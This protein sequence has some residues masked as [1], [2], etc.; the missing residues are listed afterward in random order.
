MAQGDPITP[1]PDAG[2]TD[3]ASPLAVRAFRELWSANALS[4][5]GS[6][7]QVVAAAWLMA[8]LTSSAQMI[9][10][11]QTATSLPTVCFILL[12]GALADN[13][14]RRRIMIV[15]QSAMLAVAIALAAFS[16]TGAIT[17]WMLLLL[18]FV[19]QSFNALNN[20]NWQGSVRDLLPRSLISRAVALNSTSMNLARTA[21][22]ALGGAI[23]AVAGISAA[24][25]VNACSFVAFLV[26]LR[27]WKPFARERTS[28]REPVG[29]AIL[30]G[31]RY[32]AYHPDVRNAVV[33][34]GL[35]GLSASAVFALLPVL[36]RH[37]LQTDAFTFGVLLGCFGG[38]AVI[39]A[40]CSGIVRSRF[41]PDTITRSA[42]AALTLGLL[43]LGFAHNVPVAAV[44]AAFGGAGWTMAH[45]T[46]NTTVQLA[47]APWVTARSL[48]FYQTA[49][50]A[51][52]ASGSW[53]LGGIAE[54]E[55]LSVAFLVAAGAQA[56]ATLA[57][58]AMPLPRLTGLK[59]ELLDR[60]RPPELAAGIAPDDGP[61]RIEV[62]YRV[63]EAD[64]DGFRQAMQTRR[65]IRMRDGA[66]NWALWQDVGDRTRWIESYRVADWAEYLRHNARRTEA[67]LDNMQTLRAF[68]TDS[69]GV[70]VQ[71]FLQKL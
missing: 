70:V 39:S 8:T 71:R 57:G 10:L 67:D 46:Y 65:R 62:R 33:R 41:T 64:W 30:A 56:L 61:V 21:G 58:F 60:W 68:N 43:I 23:I 31:I 51:G 47:A 44:G 42:G 5:F 32:A 59:N 11:V 4:N 49:T 63:E 22:P 69:E 2:M 50:F 38:G 48:A 55:G 25:L 27:R 40:Y 36:A 37:E 53:L 14:D 12:G 54:S 6:Q 13:F 19:S 34:G 18:I 45:S 28:L 9:A 1:P 35:S 15:T 7:I 29:P 52:M 24:F 17:P 20:P 3:P 26:A 16:F 66:R